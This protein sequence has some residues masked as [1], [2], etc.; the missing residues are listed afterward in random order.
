MVNMAKY[1]V[2]IFVGMDVM[3][4]N[5][6]SVI[7]FEADGLTA[8]WA[9]VIKAAC[10]A[11]GEDTLACIYRDERN[12]GS[13]AVF[14]GSIRYHFLIDLKGNRLYSKWKYKV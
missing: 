11:T 7:L 14:N 12:V 3:G 4:K 1:E 8:N 9:K 2:E 6:D 5:P 13:F 10:F